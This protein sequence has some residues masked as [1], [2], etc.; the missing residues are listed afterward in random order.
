MDWK[1]SF[2]IGT[3]QEAEKIIT[4]GSILH[5]DKVGTEI[6]GVVDD[7]KVYTATIS[8]DVDSIKDAKCTCGEAYC[9][10]SAVVLMK[11]FSE[12][13]SQII[14]EKLASYQNTVVKHQDNITVEAD[15]SPIYALSLQ[16]ND[17]RLV[18][19]IVI[20]NDSDENIV[21]STIRITSDTDIVAPVVIDIPLLEAGK[22]TAI[23]DKS[24]LSKIRV[25]PEEIISLS[26]RISCTL[27]FSLCIDNTEIA[28][29]Q[30]AYTLLAYNE[31]PIYAVSTDILASYIL[32][33]HPFVG[34]L[35]HDASD[36]LKKWTG[37]SSLSGYQHKDSD[38]TLQMITAAYGAIQA[39]NIVYCVPPVATNEI[40][41]SETVI[42]KIRFPDEINTQRLGTC[43]DM[44]LLFL[45]C[46]EAMGLNGFMVLVNGHIFA[47]VWLTDNHFPESVIS[48]PTQIQKRIADGMNEVIVVECTSMNSSSSVVSFD[49]A[50]KKAEST[51]DEK[52]L[53]AL[54]DEKNA[55]TFIVDVMRARLSGVKSLPVRYS[56]IDSKEIKYQDLEDSEITSASEIK[57]KSVE[58]TD[59]DFQNKQK[60]T[61][62]M[63][64]ERK[65]LDLSLRNSLINYKI[66]AGVALLVDDL[67]NLEDCISSGKSFEICERPSEW[68][69]HAIN[70]GSFETINQ[71][72]SYGSQIRSEINNLRLH[73]WTQEKE[74]N[75]SLTS[76]FRSARTSMEE[77]GVSTL[78]LALGFVK[79]M[80]PGKKSKPHYAPLILV[81]VDIAR[82][83]GNKGYTIS[84]RDD[85]IRINSTILEYFKQNFDFDLSS[86]EVLPTDDSGVDVL[87]IFTIVRKAILAKEGWD[88]IED[89]YLGNFSFSRYIMWSDVHN[90][91]D[92]LAENRIVKSL[93]EGTSMF[94]ED[95]VTIDKGD[96]Y[97]PLSVDSSQLNAVKMAVSDSS[98]VL[99]GPPGTGKSQTITALIAN[100]ITQGKTVLFVAEKMAALEVVQSRLDSL[101]L[102]N[103]CLELYS[104]K[105]TKRAVLD[106][107]K[108][109]TE[110]DV[111]GFSTDYEKRLN[112][113]KAKRQELNA[114]A[115][116]LRN[117]E[118]FGFSFRQ[119][120]DTYE[121]IPE[122]N[123][124]L[125]FSKRFIDLIDQDTIDEHVQLLKEFVFWAARVGNPSKH[126]FS[127][128][129]RT[130]YTQSFKSELEDDIYE[131]RKALKALKKISNQ[132]AELVNIDSDNVSELKEI[133]VSI[134]ES[135]SIP[136]FILSADSIDDVFSEVADYIA[137]RDS[138][139]A[140]H[141]QLAQY[142]DEEFIERDMNEYIV[143]FDVAEKKIFGKKKALDSLLEEVHSHCSRLLTIENLKSMFYSISTYQEQRK[144]LE[145]VR[146]SVFAKWN[147]IITHDVSSSELASIKNAY[148]ERLSFVGKYKNCINDESIG[149]AHAFIDSYDEVSLTE[150]RLFTLLRVN[151]KFSDCTNYVDDRIEY[152]NTIEDNL[153]D[154]KNWMA[155]RRS[156]MACEENELSEVCE[157]LTDEDVA[158]SELVDIYLK[159]VYKAMIAEVIDS[160]DCLNYFSGTDFNMLINKYREMER[161]LLAITKEEI[162]HVLTH[163]IPNTFDYKNSAQMTFI[164]KAISSGGRGFSIRTLFE[165]T[166][167]VLQYLCPC[168]LMSP[169]SVAQYLDIAKTKFDLIVFDE[170][171]QI[172]TCEAVGVLARGKNAIIV[173]DPN[174]MPPTQ[175]FS[176]AVSDEDDYELDD[177]DSI[178]D[179]SLALGLPQ[180][181]LKWH[182]RSK[183]ESLIAFSNQEY[184]ENSMLTFPSVNDRERRVKLATVNGVFAHGTERTNQKE[185]E[186]VI[187]EILR[188]FNDEN[189]R[190]SS[191]GVVTF[192]AKQQKLIEEMLEEQCNDN[193]ELLDWTLQGEKLFIKNLENVQGDERDVILFSITYGPDENGKVSMNFGPLNREGGWKR[194]NVAVSRARKEMILFTSMTS[195][196]IDLSKTKSRGVEGLRDF[197]AYAEKG[198]LQI[199][200]RSNV[201]IKEQGIRDH[202][203]KAINES[204]YKTQTDVGSSEFKIDIGVV[205]PYEEDEYLV[206]IM[207]D[208]DTYVNTT[209]TKDRELG[210]V[211]VLSG[212]GWTLYRVW[213]MDWWDDKKHVLSQLLTKL[214]QL[215]DE[216]RENFENGTN[217]FK[218]EGPAC[219]EI[220]VVTQE[221][222]ENPKVKKEKEYKPISSFD[223]HDKFEIGT[224]L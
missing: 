40:G 163:R 135:K 4:D 21:H 153:P 44:T 31:C 96:A 86:L 146:I 101:G 126:I 200:M 5:L 15:V 43:L 132:F 222:E 193:P 105:S 65:L 29:Y 26:E 10:H 195:D 211:D 172:P 191:I 167:D 9:R 115:S 199:P 176:T 12:D 102:G 164:R 53:S 18:R 104:H 98:F 190:S 171:S 205:N 78:F 112:E 37:Q 33:T 214:S 127:N 62:L 134:R 133:A 169:I 192:N 70:V 79:W 7:G 212:L 32:P 49:S 194:L 28:S 150:S 178:L 54:N 189:L 11:C 217:R 202:I 147:G 81:P 41:E 66:S 84:K 16:R 109:V 19:R 89:V 168:M 77:S 36:L 97:L 185:A 149:C 92:I 23:K 68:N 55:Y 173:G 22:E 61:K 213:S 177:L 201:E 114:Y 63:Q 204:G 160:D 165:K 75:K 223:D 181:H 58:V 39:K 113:I 69:Y 2:D 94:T 59:E 38:Y 60:N 143:K 161:Q 188:R 17:T 117:S 175:F 162:Y 197:I 138:I 27:S 52:I 124:R 157:L 215:R 203:I 47:G 100:A 42:Q 82:K 87:K 166:Y 76:L 35:I 210:Q 144:G 140:Q 170:A 196:M 6:V 216:A 34:E 198:N 67:A 180:L 158:G 91:P 103:F 106:Q 179:D 137:K 46:I 85:E 218:D 183:H 208:G 220:V 95:K 151:K 3:V 83:P 187:N 111:L 121:S 72:G 24:L 116:A 182:Y 219:E 139:E 20:K 73:A 142:F 107:L 209:N 57:I 131:Y 148:S 56:S 118:R 129:R 120:L 136:E 30:S 64:W 50:V 145:T 88:L 154:L 110:L 99:H 125:R 184:Y 174:Q 25:K 74:L 130:E 186:A 93:I 128:V 80:E 8:L 156:F 108:Q 119:L 13:G 48:D 159:T 71:L 123:Q 155:Y 45:A 51:I 1:K 122:N 14:G 207:L 90:N 152:C 141:Q 206:G 221:K 224:R